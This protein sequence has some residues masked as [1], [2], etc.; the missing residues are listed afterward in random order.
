MN[1]MQLGIILVILASFAISAYYY[2]SM[3]G[4]L[5]SHWNLQGDADGYSGKLFGMFFVPALLAVMCF[6]LY[7][8]PNLDPL[9]ANVA[10]FREHYDRFILILAL[11]M[12]YIHAL[13]IYWNLGRQFDFGQYL[14]PA[15]G[16]L[17]LAV[18]KL[19]ENAKPN[20]FI[21]IRTP[22]TLS[23]EKVWEKTHRIG[24]KLFF[25]TGIVSFMGIF[26]PQISLLIVLAMALAIIVWSLVFSFVEY[27]KEMGGKQRVDKK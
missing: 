6:I 23:S 3:P 19:V 11:F 25:A 10:K 16:I 24:G 1:K 14:S 9:K 17:F 5:A 13:T 26:F 12:L 22:W 18:G 2:P 8:I 7:F 21:G 20:W 27:K 15:F 4:R